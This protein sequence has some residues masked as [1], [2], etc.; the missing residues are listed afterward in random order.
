ML[1]RMTR[2]VFKNEH[3]QKAAGGISSIGQIPQCLRGCIHHKEPRYPSP[4]YQTHHIDQHRR[5]Y[6]FGRT[7]GRG[8][9][10][11]RCGM[12]SIELRAGAGAD[13]VSWL[14]WSGRRRS[15]GVS[16]VGKPGWRGLRGAMR[17][18]RSELCETLHGRIRY[19]RFGKPT[20]WSRVQL[21]AQPKQTL[22]AYIHEIPF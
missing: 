2:L 10:F 5:I 4:G 22:T 3:M 20:A 14:G 18:G 15:G 17:S 12:S 8:H 19:R 16:A 7:A 21:S 6:I 11:S 1:L 13:V 9:V